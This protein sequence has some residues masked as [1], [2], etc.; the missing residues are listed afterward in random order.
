[1]HVNILC[2]SGSL[3][4]GSFNTATLHAATR[5]APDDMILTVFSEMGHL[6]LFNPDREEQYIP[7]VAR[8]RAAVKLADGFIFASPE[9]AHGI[10]GVMKNALDWL[11]GDE[12][13][14]YKPVM[15]IN[16]SPRASHGQ[17][18]LREVLTTMSV[19]MVDE[20]A[21]SV[22]LLGSGLDVDGIIKHPEISNLLTRSLDVFGNA[23]RAH[24]A[25]GFV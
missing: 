6:P 20:A 21:V 11:V 10:S 7:S 17:A 23:V 13:F 16:T 14:P 8:L 12:A 25:S 9:Y 4:N 1:M 3:R 2:L 24:D 22:P 19:S 5:L 15:L 18:A